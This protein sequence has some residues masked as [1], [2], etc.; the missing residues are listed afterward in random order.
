MQ[1]TLAA[2]R[3]LVAGSCGEAAV[4]QE[5]AAVPL[6][7][8]RTGGKQQQ[9]FAADQHA[10]WSTLP[11]IPSDAYPGGE[12]SMDESD[13][14]DTDEQTSV[15]CTS[16]A[17]KTECEEISE[18]YTW[19]RSKNYQ[20]GFGATAEEQPVPRLVQ[21]QV[22]AGVK[23]VSCS[24]FHTIVVTSCG[25]VLTWGFGGA[26]GRLGLTSC[27]GGEPMGC[28]MTPTCIPEFGQGHHHALK[29]SAGCDHTLAM[30][31]SGKILVWGSNE[32]GQL[33]VAGTPTGEKSVVCRPVLVKAGP[34]K[35]LRVLDIAAGHSHSL[36]IV[37]GSGVWA[38]GSNSLGATGLGAPPTGPIGPVATPQQLP[39]LKGTAAFASAAS[40]V[41]VV[42]GAHGDAI[43]FGCAIAKNSCTGMPSDSKFYVPQRV[44]RNVAQKHKGS[45][46]EVDEEWQLQKGSGMSPLHSVALSSE[47]AFGV[48]GHG[49]IWM[50]RTASCRPCVAERLLIDAKFGMR[51]QGRTLQEVA[52]LDGAHVRWRSVAIAESL[53]AVWATDDSPSGCL[54]HLRRNPSLASDQREDWSA[55]RSELLS[56]VTS[57]CCGHEHQTAIVSYRRHRANSTLTKQI[58]GPPLYPI[59]A[60]ETPNISD[61]GVGGHV[62]P[63][64]G[65][66][67]QPCTPEG[68]HPGSLPSGCI[69][70]GAEAETRPPRQAPRSLQEICEDKLCTSLNPRNFNVLCDV[71]W[72]L[73]R[74]V[75]ID[76]AFDFLFANAALMFSRQ[77]LPILAQ[78]SPEIL[79]AL[80]A[81]V[82]SMPCS[83]SACLEGMASGSPGP[84]DDLL[85]GA[86]YV[87]PTLGPNDN[88]ALA[89][90][91]SHEAGVF[92]ARRKRRGQGGNNKT[93]TPES[94]PLQRAFPHIP[95]AKKSTSPLFQV[96]KPQFSLTRP[97]QEEAW[98][99]VSARRKM[100]TGL[101]GR[102][103]KAAGTHLSPA[104]VPAKLRTPKIAACESPTLCSV[105]SPTGPKA[106]N[107]DTVL[108]QQL[109]LST[110]V[111]AGRASAGSQTR[112]GPAQA[113][114]E[115]S[116]GPSAILAA[117]MQSAQV[118]TAA[119]Q[120]ARVKSSPAKP[121]STEGDTSTA[122]P[123]Q[124]SLSAVDGA[125]AASDPESVV[126]R[127]SSGKASNKTCWSSPKV[128]SDNHANL[129]EVLAVERG[130]IGALADG[131]SKKDSR[132]K[133]S[134]ESTKCAWG[135]EAKPSEQPKGT[136]MYNLQQQE[137]QEKERQKEQ[138]EI[139]EIEAM[140]AALDVA[141]Q[142]EEREFLGIQS[143]STATAE[144][145]TV[146]R[147]KTRN[148]NDKGLA[149]SEAGKFSHG[150][151]TW[152]KH[153]S[154]S[155]SGWDSWIGF[156]NSE[157]NA[158]ASN[159]SSGKS[160]RR[161]RNQ[162][163][164]AETQA[165]QGQR[166]KPKD[167]VA[168]MCR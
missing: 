118:Q 45:D 95:A 10:E 116:A 25:S 42:I 12:I 2:L 38:W 125:A 166:W 8:N 51:S 39:H 107:P 112:S 66:I 94:A 37:E 160:R 88:T 134:E 168:T 29:A 79:L 60:D 97:A 132:R 138:D 69:E 101:S 17:G 119:K 111:R 14:E 80:Q 27:D 155:A 135:F 19:G 58:S 30:T 50:W 150:S 44:R 21:L 163:L 137:V 34:L 151:S 52:P 4:F 41:S 32:F 108:T 167:A 22:K 145:R 129:R 57:V 3:G 109:P 61:F 81:G 86:P 103:S 154:W 143:D 102:L 75:L 96:A 123:S 28:V 82:S 136:S 54:W 11:D 62:F 47:A 5:A 6:Q 67:L 153:K 117:A 35:G 126:A 121:T 99:I 127:A 100:C 33:G 70:S 130:S 83:P 16:A 124:T 165:G 113:P 13:V 122:D 90:D 72:E 114:T 131:A 98:V 133:F 158:S 141:E 128:A 91:I 110:F 31:A 78:L 49:N 105:R 40:H 120:K 115:A 36:C 159:G 92:S 23:M 161:V 140:F 24:R 59:I 15:S 152:D 157:S 1:T 48:D 147:K 76:R 7:V 43:M 89:D 68:L 9:Q 149:R 63:E 148:G 156:D 18:L 55:E 139:R 144:A 146:V 20:L 53:G 46:L 71:A 56:Q 93:G 77:Y 142:E 85:Q 74:P 65:S 64:L 26:T 104:Q 73:N 87:S 164:G 84:W 106:A 162:G